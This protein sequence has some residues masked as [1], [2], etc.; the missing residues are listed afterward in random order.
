MFGDDT[1]LIIGIAAVRSTEYGGRG[2]A[3]TENDAGGGGA[4]VEVPLVGALR[5]A[6]TTS[7]LR[8]F[9]TSTDYQSSPRSQDE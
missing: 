5:Q 9:D 8:Y 6:G 2:D 1:I 4:G 3:A 7:L